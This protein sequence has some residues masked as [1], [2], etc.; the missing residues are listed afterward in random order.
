MSHRSYC[1]GSV[2]LLLAWACP[3]ASAQGGGGILVTEGGTSAAIQQAKDVKQ[4]TDEDKATDAGAT[5]EEPTTIVPEQSADKRQR[6]IVFEKYDKSMILWVGPT[7]DGCWLLISNPNYSQKFVFK[8]KDGSFSREV[9][10]GRV[11]R[12]NFVVCPD[13]SL[14]VMRSDDS[15]ADLLIKISHAGDIVWQKRSTQWSDKYST[16]EI[17]SVCGKPFIKGSKLGNTD[18]VLIINLDGEIDRHV[19]S[20]V[21][22]LLRDTPVMYTSESGVSYALAHDGL[23][24]TRYLIEDGGGSVRRILV[25]GLGNQTCIVTFSVTCSP[26][27]GGG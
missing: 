23:N 24:L 19:S 22:N 18:T 5:A 25:R 7:P 1:V 10:V 2:L 20:A 11:L 21:V 17:S 12:K 16:S 14:L 26:K 9:D 4:H 27:V 6:R 15:L 8:N 13:S 3:G